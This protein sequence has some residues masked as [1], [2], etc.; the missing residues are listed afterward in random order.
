[1]LVNSETT[2]HCMPRHA[3]APGTNDFIS[4]AA[5]LTR[6]NRGLRVEE[7]PKKDDY[8]QNHHPLAAIDKVQ[9]CR[10]LDLDLN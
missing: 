2:T 6:K 9:G 3:P 4:T 7:E 10:D 5:T 8:W 1:M